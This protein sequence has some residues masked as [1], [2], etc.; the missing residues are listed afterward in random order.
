MTSWSEPSRVKVLVGRV[1][2]EHPDELKV[3]PGKVVYEGQPKLGWDK[4]KAV[5]HLVEALDLDREE[6]VALYVGD[7]ITDEDAFE[8]LKG[9]GMGVFVG[10]P[11]DPELAGRPTA[12]DF[13]LISVKEVERFLRTLA[14]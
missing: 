4:G 12:A 5:L 14:R 2:A 9:T 3:T 1:L 10:N 7:D 11:D 6:I 13:V 8:A